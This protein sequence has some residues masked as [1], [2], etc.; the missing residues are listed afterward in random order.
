[1]K[2]TSL[3]SID[4]KFELKVGTDIY[5]AVVLPTVGDWMNSNQLDHLNLLNS[6]LDKADWESTA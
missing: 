5:L 2:L 6:P 1:M 3:T 4:A